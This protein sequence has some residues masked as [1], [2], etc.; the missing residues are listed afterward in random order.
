ML[1]YKGVFAPFGARKIPIFRLETTENVKY[2]S[3][4]EHDK[5]E[6]ALK[7]LTLIPLDPDPGLNLLFFFFF[8]FFFFWNEQSVKCSDNINNQP[9]IQILPFE[10]SQT[11]PH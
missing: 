11:N 6:K 4:K 1:G 2:Q 3:F 5:A 9:S 7:R 8:F 10:P